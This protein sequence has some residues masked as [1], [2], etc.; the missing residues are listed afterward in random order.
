[1]ASLCVEREPVMSKYS[2]CHLK[3]VALAV[4]PPLGTLPDQEATVTAP[5]DELMAFTAP[6]AID[7]VP[8]TFSLT[9][10]VSPKY[11]PD[12]V[13]DKPEVVAVILKV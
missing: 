1:M 9:I 3:T 4:K 11:N 2:L 13:A 5:V 8:P 6:W 10:T 12:V 7:S